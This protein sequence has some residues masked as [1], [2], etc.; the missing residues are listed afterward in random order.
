MTLILLIALLASPA[1]CEGEVRPRPA[2]SFWCVE[3]GARVRVE[4]GE[5]DVNEA[6]G[7]GVAVLWAQGWYR[8]VEINGETVAGEHRLYLPAI[9]GM[10]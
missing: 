8:T 10:R 6:E 1:L 3:P 2:V 9:V 5:W 4:G 7:A